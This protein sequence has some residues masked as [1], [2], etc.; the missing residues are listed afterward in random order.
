MEISRFIEEGYK[1]VLK[2]N[3][4]GK[5]KRESEN[6]CQVI[7]SCLV[8]HFQDE[9]FIIFP[10]HYL[11]KS[12]TRFGLGYIDFVFGVQKWSIWCITN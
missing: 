12:D 2:E 11:H 3:S 10:Q 9:Q 4:F 6:L 5:N 1:T 7:L 8:R